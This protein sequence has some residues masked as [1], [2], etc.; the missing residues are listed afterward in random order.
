MPF[1]FNQGQACRI[2]QHWSP[3]GVSPHGS[4]PRLTLSGEVYWDS[5]REAAEC[6]VRKLSGVTGVTNLIT[7]KDIRR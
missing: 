1:D 3:L 2:A 5:D 6:T 4:Y 7:T